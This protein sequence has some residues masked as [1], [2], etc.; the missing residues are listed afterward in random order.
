MQPS[1]VPNVSEEHVTDKSAEG[2]DDEG[3]SEDEA[4]AKV[5]IDWTN[6]MLGFGFSTERATRALLMTTKDLIL[7]E[8]VLRSWQKFGVPE[9]KLG[10]GPYVRG[11]WTTMDD[12]A[13]R[14]EEPLLMKE[15]R[16]K[17]GRE[18]VLE[19]SEFLQDFEE[20]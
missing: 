14:K 1:A 3:M 9:A 2:T 5:I 13:L 17:H 12:E 15:L 19:R 10:N 4:G 6:E 11:V 8:T 18:N 16:S 20:E 7:A